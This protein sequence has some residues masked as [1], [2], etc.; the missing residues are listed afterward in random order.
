VLAGELEDEPGVD[1]AEDR[2]LGPRGVAQQPLD[3]GPGE[4]G[5]DRQ[6][7]AL[8]HQRLVSG[9]PQLVAAPRGAAVLPDEG[10]VDRLAAVRVPGDDGLAL[11]GDPDRIEVGA[12]D[13]RRGDR[14]GGDPPGHLP[15]LVRVVLD[16][17]GLREEL[18]EL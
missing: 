6:P 7:G 8:A 13:P 18:L 15:D 2:P 5:V 11:V 14:L 16:P 3:L 17:A 9:L 4:V 12:L 1:R 10:P